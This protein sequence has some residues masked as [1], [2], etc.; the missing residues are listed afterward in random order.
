M[1]IDLAFNDTQRLIQS[2]ASDFFRRTCPTPVVRELAESEPGFSMD[3]WR[4]MAGL[5]WHGITF[6]EAYDG[7]GG[8]FLDLYPLYEEMGRFIVPGPH[9]E[10]VGLAGHLIEAYASDSLKSELLP[11]VSLGTALVSLALSEPNG[12]QG[13]RAV[14][15]AAAPSGGGGYTLN[16]TKLLVPY[17]AAADWL[18][19]PARTGAGTSGSD[20]I[21]LLLVSTKSRGLA[22]S[23]M[24]TISGLPLFAADFAAVEVPQD[25]IVGAVDAAWPGIAACLTRG[26]VLVSAMIVGAAERV[27]E[28]TVNYAK[29]RVQF[30]QPIG[31]YQAVQNMVTDILLETHLAKLLT[32]QAAWRLDAGLPYEREAAIAKASASRGSRRLMVRAHDVHAGV[33]FMLHHDLQLFSRRADYWESYLGDVRFQSDAIFATR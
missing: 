29:D 5:G 17:A 6:P 32:R 19:V 23:R 2:T 21:S 13:H 4:E 1:T 14:E 8:S 15:L 9:L 27:L 12:E 3:M 7:S 28:M 30:G 20:G 10:T 33:G 24:R 16:G 31:R 22:L 11:A 26:A 25:R 18:L